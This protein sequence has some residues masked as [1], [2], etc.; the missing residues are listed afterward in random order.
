M[1][2]HLSIVILL[3]KHDALTS[4]ISCTNAQAKNLFQVRGKG[5]Y[6]TKKEKRYF[7]SSIR[8]LVRWDEPIGIYP[9]EQGRIWISTISIS[10]L[11]LFCISTSQYV[12]WYIIIIL[13][14]L[15]TEIGIKLKFKTLLP[16]NI[17]SISFFCLCTLF[18]LHCHSLTSSLSICWSLM[19]HIQN[20]HNL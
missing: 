16:L 15:V 3:D 20:Q 10:F 17:V 4:I 12:T 9:F 6:S 18:S 1:H 7:L 8:I 11:Y 13:I 2:I 5:G 19:I 14:R